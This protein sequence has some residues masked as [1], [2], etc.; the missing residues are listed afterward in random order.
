MSDRL[1]PE[2]L[3]VYRLIRDGGGFWTP[4]DVAR[5]LIPGEPL[6]RASATASRWLMALA[7][8]NHIRINPLARR[9]PSYGVTALCTPIEGEPMPPGNDQN[10]A[11][12]A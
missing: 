11:V 4:S 6:N 7:R 3:Q 5:H 1:S 9:Y 8:R 12:P 10:P 2:A